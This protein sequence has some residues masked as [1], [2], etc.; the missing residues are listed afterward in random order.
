VSKQDLIHVEV[1]DG[2]NRNDLDADKTCMS[3]RELVRVTRPVQRIVEDGVFGKLSYRPVV[4]DVWREE[5]LVVGPH[6]V[7]L[8]NR[9]NLNGQH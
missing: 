2:C 5:V 1:G 8:S 7:I 4:S 9:S 6:V 3:H